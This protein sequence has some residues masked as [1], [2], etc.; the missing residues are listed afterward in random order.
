MLSQFVYLENMSSERERESERV[1]EN[2]CVRERVRMRLSKR[3]DVGGV[4]KR[5]REM[6]R[7]RVRMPKKFLRNFKSCLKKAKFCEILLP[8]L[9][10]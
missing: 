1:N 9:T 10:F 7:E 2:V 4:R 3:E 5:E 8:N 6:A